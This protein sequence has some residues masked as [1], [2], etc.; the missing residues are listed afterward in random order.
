MKYSLIVLFFINYSYANVVVEQ[1][2]HAV[3]NFPCMECHKNKDV[4]EVKLPLSKPHEHLKFDHH[5]E[6]R[7]CFSCHDKKDR[8]Y[9]HLY[10]GKKIS[11]DEGYELCIQCHGEKKKDWENGIHGKQIGKW[12]GE[13]FRFSCTHCHDPHHPQFRLMMADPG[14]VHPNKEGHK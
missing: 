1:R 3:K 10:S 12:N 9:L 6:I 4:S 7:N 8:D 14:P 5:D 13:K 11:F 2:K